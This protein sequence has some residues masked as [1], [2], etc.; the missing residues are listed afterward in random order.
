M[1][2]IILTTVVASLAAVSSSLADG[3]AAYV[4]CSACHGADGKGMPV[5]AKKMAP[6]LAGSKV[7]TG[8]ASIL[9][10]SILKGIKKEG[11]DY[12]GMMMP[13]EAAYADDQKLADVMTYVRQSFDNKAAAV[14]KEDAAKYRAQWKDIKE[15]V[16][17]AKLE[18][19]TKKSAE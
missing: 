3:K 19:L 1:K 8:D 2:K 6:S 5:G 9:A 7:V 4:T 17:R 11:T 18:E 13:L 15:P 16:T 10:L 12:L 14:T